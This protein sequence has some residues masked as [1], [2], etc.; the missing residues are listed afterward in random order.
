MNT[1]WVFVAKSVGRPAASFPKMRA[2]LVSFGA[3]CGR[4]IAFWFNMNEKRLRSELELFL[5]HSFR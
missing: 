4:V 3:T 5:T 2:K 1:G